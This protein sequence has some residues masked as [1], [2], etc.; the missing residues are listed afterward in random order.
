MLGLAVAALIHP[1]ALALGHPG[2]ARVSL[3]LAVPHAAMAA[4]LLAYLMS[5][6]LLM[7][8]PAR[9]LLSLAWAPIYMA[10]KLII[11][12]GAA[13]IAGSGRPASR[14]PRQALRDALAGGRE[15]E[16]IN[17]INSRRTIDSGFDDR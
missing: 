7:G 8:L 5:P 2:L 14:S 10:W 15:V 4:A 13:P 1:L 16:L 6:F 17:Y 3:L 12:T 9:Y 11:A